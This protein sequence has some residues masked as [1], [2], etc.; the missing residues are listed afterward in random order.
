MG[1]RIYHVRCSKESKY[2]PRYNHFRHRQKFSLFEGQRALVEFGAFLSL[3]PLLHLSPKGDG[4]PVLVIPGL[5]AGDDSTFALR[6]VLQSRGYAVEGWGLGRNRGLR[7]RVQESMLGGVR[8][9]SD[10]HR[11]KI[12][13]IGWSLGASSHENLRREFQS[14]VISLGS[15]FGGSPRSTNAWQV[16]ELAS[17]DSVDDAHHVAALSVAPPVPTDNCDL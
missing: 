15:P 5:M 17:G 6:K 4:H 3:L 7:E 8:A 13:I 2:S 14:A 12:S 16:Y 1:F 10:L 9:L 11:K